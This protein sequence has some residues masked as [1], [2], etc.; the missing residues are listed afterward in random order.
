MFSVRSI[1]N[2]RS[3]A[4]VID[5]AWWPDRSLPRAET[6]SSA[7]RSLPTSATWRNKVVPREELSRSTR[8]ELPT[9]AFGSAWFAFLMVDSRALSRPGRLSRRQMPWPQAV[10]L[11]VGTAAVTWM[12]SAVFDTRGPDRVIGPY[13]VPL[14]AEIVLGVLAVAAGLTAVV[15]IV[16]HERHA[17]RG[18]TFA[19]TA[20]L[21]VNC[22]FATGWWRTATGMGKGA[23]IG[24]GM[25]VFAGPL[26]IVTFLAAAV[27]VQLA[28]RRQN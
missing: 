22:V 12:V 11:C 23:N 16:R 6:H 27:A 20:T 3:R 1:K 15:A 26:V 4:P 8:V 24:G 13:D 17:H 25:F 10:A 9:V 18:P 5:G 19:T 2:R 14:A 28:T 21:I 7:E